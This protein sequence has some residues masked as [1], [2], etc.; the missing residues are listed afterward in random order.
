MIFIH[1]LHHTLDQ[2]SLNEYIGSGWH[3]RLAYALYKTKKI[4]SILVRLKNKKE[5]EF[6]IGIK[7]I[8]LNKRLG[9][10]FGYLGLNICDKLKYLIEEIRKIDK[11]IIVYIHEWKAL[12]SLIAIKCLSS[13]RDIVIILQQ[14]HLPPYAYLHYLK[15]QRRSSLLYKFLYY[16]E[17]KL[18]LKNSNI[19][20]IYVLNKIEKNIYTSLFNDKIVRIQTMG[21]MFPDKKPET[22]L[23]KHQIIYVGPITLNSYRGGDLL[24]KYFIKRNLRDR[25]FNLTMIGPADRRLC[26]YA[27]TH[28]IDCKGVLAHSQVIRELKNASIFIWP[29]SKTVFWGG[30][31]VSVMEAFASNIPVASSTLIHHEGN[32]EKLGWILPWREVGEYEI[33]KS[34]DA[35]LEEFLNKKIEPYDEAKPYYD[36][37]FIVNKI[38]KDIKKL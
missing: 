5:P 30:I 17:Y 12:N 27:R 10:S 2:S 19:K 34:L 28:G 33:F 8:T 4:P 36:W 31:G 37:R 16:Y 25:G 15:K 9:V 35:V 21:V 26:E 13:I 14:H 38:L 6:V 22:P 24:I 3:V 23:N 11:D 7:Y 20:V 1:F 29:A 32:I 18:L